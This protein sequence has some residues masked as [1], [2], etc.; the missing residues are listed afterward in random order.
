[1]T[2]IGGRGTDEYIVGSAND[3]LDP[4]VQPLTIQGGAGFNFRRAGPGPPR[5]RARE[6]HP[7][8]VTEPNG[9]TGR[10]R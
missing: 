6:Q 4:I 8:P 7:D 10:G 3:T 1:V 9:R 2:F 5:R